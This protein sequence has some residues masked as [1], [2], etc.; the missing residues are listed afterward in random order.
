MAA[1]AAQHNRILCWF[2]VKWTKRPGDLNSRD[3]QDTV[4]FFAWG[5]ERTGKQG[6]IVPPLFVPEARP[7][8]GSCPHGALSSGR[9]FGFSHSHWLNAIELAA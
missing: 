4:G 2:T 7:A 1:L 6:G 5:P 8:L 3:G 9:V